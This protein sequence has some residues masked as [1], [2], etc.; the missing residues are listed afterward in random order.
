MAATAGRAGVFLALAGL[1]VV[2]V[3]V[4]SSRVE[5]EGEDEG[6]PEVGQN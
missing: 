5:G 6:Q 4:E 1:V 2:L 3:E